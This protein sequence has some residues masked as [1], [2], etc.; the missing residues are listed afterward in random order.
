MIRFFLVWITFVGAA[1][2]CAWGPSDSGAGTKHV[3]FV[4]GDEEY[5]SEESMPMFARVLERDYPIRTTVLYA[6][7]PESGEIDPEWVED[8][9]GLE[10]LETADLAVFFVRYR[11]L[12][13]EQLNHFLRYCRSG[14]PRIA[15]RPS[16]H[17]F[18]Y[19]VDKSDPRTRWD[20]GF[21][22]EF[23]GQRFIGY[24][25]GETDVTL[26]DARKDH[27]I[28]RGV[29]SFHA[30][31]W[32]YTAEKKGENPLPDTV[33]PLL[34]GHPVG[35][36][37]KNGPFPQACAWTLNEP[38]E[39]GIVPRVFYTS[40]GHPLDFKRPQARRLV[41]N[42]CLWALGMEHHIPPDGASAQTV[43]PYEPTPSKVGGHK[44][45]VFPPE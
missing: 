34:I 8:I 9:P 42:A 25:G 31:S 6:V 41:V 10:A 7:H 36:E 44:R 35:A 32:L 12:P 14:K 27:P 20:Y 39:D 1:V 11:K 33:R 29:T 22:S 3:V 17:A 21:G 18:R 2:G 23:F 16:N 45:G 13:D 40:L 24:Q 26:V 30:R 5:R 37:Y 38:R 43:G 28:L 19:R 4:T 15:L